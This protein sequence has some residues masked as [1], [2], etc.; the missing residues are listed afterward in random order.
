MDPLVEPPHGEGFQLWKNVSD[1]F[2]INPVFTTPHDLAVWM[3]QNYCTVGGTMPYDDAMRFINV[4]GA[5]TTVITDGHVVDGG[6]CT[7]TAPNDT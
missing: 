2:P 7:G 3:S 1:G 6:T 5:P 4:G